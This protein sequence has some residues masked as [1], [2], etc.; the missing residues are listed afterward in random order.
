MVVNS[1][2]YLYWFLRTSLKG[3]FLRQIARTIPEKKLQVKYK[4]GP[5]LIKVGSVPKLSRVLFPTRTRLMFW[6]VPSDDH[7][8]R[9]SFSPFGV[10]QRARD[11]MRLT[12]DRRTGRSLARCFLWRAN[13]LLFGLSPDGVY[14]ASLV[15]SGPVVFYTAI[16]IH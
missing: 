7:L 14:P 9:I 3:G 15:T 4:F 11:L 5:L 16:T 10:P 12:Q 1:F 8:S 6:C 13:C 2:F